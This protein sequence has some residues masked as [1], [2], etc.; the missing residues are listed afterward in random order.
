MPPT[1]SMRWSKAAL[2]AFDTRSHTQKLLKWWIPAERHLYTHHLWCLLVATDSYCG[3]NE[4][5]PRETQLNLSLGPSVACNLS[6]SP[7]A[8]DSDVE[9]VNLLAFVVYRYCSNDKSMSEMNFVLFI[10]WHLSVWSEFQGLDGRLSKL[11]LNCVPDLYDEFEQGEREMDYIRRKTMVIVAF[12]ESTPWD[13][14][15]KKKPSYFS[16]CRELYEVD[17]V[18]N[19]KVDIFLHFLR[20]T[21]TLSSQGYMVCIAS[22][23]QCIS[24]G[25]ED[26]ILQYKILTIPYFLLTSSPENTQQ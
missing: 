3:D 10:L 14:P 18:D 15:R 9:S 21:F 24:S 4:F 2:D 1:G 25:H 17:E 13:S 16:K 26:N 6:P 23:S 7:W 19:G 5:S 11:G 12:W 20:I 8:A 22:I